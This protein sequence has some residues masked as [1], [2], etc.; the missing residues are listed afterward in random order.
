MTQGLL[1]SR[2]HK[3]KLATKKIRNPTEDNIKNFKEFLSLYNK[4][5]RVAKVKYYE[6]KF[7]EISNDIKKTW[8]ITREALGTKRVRRMFPSKFNYSNKVF[9]GFKD[10]ADGFNTFFSS[11]AEELALKVPQTAKNFIDFLGERVTNNFVFATVTPQ[12]LFDIINKMKPKRSAGP[13]NISTKLLKEILPIIISP[14]CH[15]FNLSLQTGY[16]PPRFKLAKVIPI[17]KT[18]DRDTFNN[19]RP[20]SLLS[21]FSKVLEKVVAKQMYAFLY[22]NNVLYKHQYGFRRGHS[23]SHVLMHFLLKI[24]DAL[25]KNVPEYTLGI[26]LDLKKAF[27]TVNH[28]ILLQKLEHYGFRGV[29]NYWFD[30]YLS[31]RFQYV[32]IE[33]YNSDKREI[34]HGV[35]QGSVLG[36]LLFLL[37][38]NDLAKASSFL[39][40]LFADDTTLQLSSNNVIQLFSEANKQLENISLWFQSN[41]LTLN[42]SKT[43]YIVFRSKNMS[44][45]TNISLKI[46]N[47]EISR[48]GLNMTEQHFKF[49]GHIIDEHL[50]WTPHIKHV[51]NKISTGN[52]LLAK[53]KNI[54][55]KKILMNIYNALIRPHLEYGILAWGGVGITKLKGLISV[56]KKAIRNIAGQQPSAHTNP[57]FVMLRVLKFKDLFKMN[58]SIFM[59]KFKNNLL[60]N[61]FL[62][63]FTP[64]NAPNRT[65]SYKV[66]KS[67]ISF[68][69]QFPAA[70]LPKTWNDLGNSIKASETLSVFKG[71][72]TG[73]LIS[74]YNEV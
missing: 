21:S 59:Y 2:K 32:S 5:I 40:F 1:K 33:G 9:D 74:Q 52:F 53:A 50:S 12:S 61:S 23:T 48:I 51:Q 25:H 18:G 62:N 10:I 41:K 6:N 55:P 38:I 31:E 8:E 35:P 46:G 56:Q 66:I 65:N 54:L 15:I 72:I 63:M 42:I 68:L 4:I 7:R 17:F 71:S 19:Y 67:R 11:V 49:L 36:P 44:L 29:S 57:L 64:C 43:R 34:K 14:L 69:D 39:T 13:D 16:V 70:Y 27:D 24:H 73:S 20:I 45:P 26:F 47:E 28:R 3:D 60:P 22:S 37:F 30:N 58:S